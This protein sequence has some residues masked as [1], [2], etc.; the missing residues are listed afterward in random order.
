MTAFFGFAERQATK[1]IA[2]FQWEQ[3]FSTQNGW[4]P[5]SIE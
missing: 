5:G 3:I 1:N 2:E 4:K